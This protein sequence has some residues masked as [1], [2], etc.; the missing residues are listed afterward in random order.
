ML[1]TEEL[2]TANIN[3]KTR[4][5]TDFLNP[6][7]EYVMLAEMVHDGTMPDD[8]LKEWQPVDYESHFAGSAF[9]GAKTVLAAYREIGHRDHEQFEQAVMSLVDAIAEHQAQSVKVPNALTEIRHLRD[10]VAA[11]ISGEHLIPDDSAEDVQ[12]AI[13][14]LFDRDD[15]T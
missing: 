8:D 12:S 9:A 2:R 5:A 7:N 1:R 15:A 6:F 11:F 14:D 3:P 10:A 4:L 13:D